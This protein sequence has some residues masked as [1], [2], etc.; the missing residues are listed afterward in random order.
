MITSTATIMASTVIE[1][2]LFSTFMILSSVSLM[3]LVRRRVI[4]NLRA[5]NDNVSSGL[6]RRARTAVFA[7]EMAKSPLIVANILLMLTVTAHWLLGIHKLFIGVVHLGGGKAAIDYYND[8]QDKLSIAR[9]S[10]LFVDMLIGDAIITYRAW[11][12]WE[13]HHFVV[14]IPTMTISAFI[15]SGIGLLHELAAAR[16]STTAPG[17]SSSSSP[18]LRAPCSTRSPS[19]ASPPRPAF[20]SC[21]SASGSASRRGPRAR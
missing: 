11:I 9:A 1:C 12:V 5:Q 10:L 14:I 8:F 17:R 16:P 2:T 20:R 4:P 3:L 13:R 15:V 21:S 18:T 7:K 19:T 6:A